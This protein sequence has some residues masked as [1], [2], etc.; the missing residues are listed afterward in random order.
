MLDKKKIDWPRFW[1][2]A[3]TVLLLGICVVH[4]LRAQE[5]LDFIPIN[6]TYQNYNPI[7]R[8]LSGQ[9]PYKDFNDYLGMGHLLWGSLFTMLWGGDYAASLSA[10]T[11]LS[12]GVAVLVSLVLANTLLGD[13][14]L[15]CAATLLALIAVL[16][17]DEA[18]PENSNTF[19]LLQSM[20]VPG[21]SARM[22]RG[23]APVLLVLALLFG[24]FLIRK[25]GL[26]SRMKASR[27]ELLLTALCGMCGGC[28]FTHSNDYGISSWLCF[29]LMVGVFALAR[30]RKVM[31]VLQHMAV[32][33]AASAVGLCL[34]VT[35][36]TRGNLVSWLK[37][38]FGTGGYQSWY[39]ISNHSF[40]LYDVDFNFY[41][42]LQA[43]LVLVY[44][45]LILRR[46]GDG[47]ALHRFGIPAVLNMT[48]FCAT[49]EYK[50]ISGGILHEMAFLILGLTILYEA[51]RF[52]MHRMEKAK[53]NARDISLLQYGSAF[54]AT[55]WIC[56]AGMDTGLVL[57]DKGRGEYF[58]NLGGYMKSLAASIKDA[59]AFLDGKTV[60]STYSSALEADMGQ[61]Q[62]SGYDYIIHVLGDDARA[63]YKD[64]FD[65][66]NFDYVATIKREYNAWEYWVSAANWFLYQDLYENYH[67]VF[68]NEYEVFWE[69]NA[70]DQ[71]FVLPGTEVDVEVVAE[72]D[73]VSKIIV[74][75]DESLNG[76]ADIHVNCS[77]ILEDSLRGKLT[78]ASLVN[79]AGTSQQASIESEDEN[80]EEEE[81]QGQEKTIQSEDYS[82]M[83]AQQLNQINLPSGSN[84]T[85][86]VEV[87]NGYGEVTLTSQPKSATSL[88]LTDVYCNKV[89][90]VFD[91]FVMDVTVEQN[92]H[93]QTQ[94]VFPGTVRNYSAVQEIRAVQCGGAE[95]PVEKV[96]YKNEDICLLVDCDLQTVETLLNGNNCVQVLR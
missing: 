81:T 14:R 74:T 95:I 78:I 44:L 24:E 11:F 10:F 72:N 20:I 46:K 27:K 30:T 9:V 82:A 13:K 15:A 42:L 50:L 45:V 76:F 79:I 7:R 64:V 77:A 62:P 51:V 4:A 17:I 36:A 61:F 58:P 93:Q 54:L 71:S 86:S 63:E 90:T 65:A 60:F 37:A 89:Y 94:L 91:N 59:E 35:I 47:Y 32:Y 43:G 40:F 33:F 26:F 5:Y 48:A 68:S 73:S 69:K 8:F 52:V 1:F 75:G 29:G 53:N 92:S 85:I 25:F 87:V 3:G 19:S 31:A 84:T 21:N 88:E 28:V 6:G 23:A 56:S 16:L 67:P 83:M 12:V 49:N 66:G 96:S 38:T 2:V 80:S 57:L 41:S 70:P 34:F 18:V 39:Y 22:I 55:V